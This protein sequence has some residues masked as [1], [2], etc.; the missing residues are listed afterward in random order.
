[1]GKLKRVLLIDDSEIDT[2]V[3]QRVIE[4]AG[5]A[6]NIMVKH[7][8]IEALEY[9]KLP[10]NQDQLPELIFLDINMPFMNGF[11][12]IQAFDG[13]PESVREKCKIM[14]LSSSYHSKDIKRMTSHPSVLEFITKPLSQSILDRLDPI[15]QSPD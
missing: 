9:L 6:E 5:F 13:L 2:F 14:V 10:N 3:S 7:S 11:G 15:S 12:F 4:R 1:M 8:A